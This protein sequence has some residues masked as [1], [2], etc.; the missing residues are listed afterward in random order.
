[1]HRTAALA[2]LASL[3]LAPSA[4]GDIVLLKDGRSI[5][6]IKVR[7]DGDFYVLQYVHG[8]VRLPASEVKDAYIEVNGAFEPR[9][10]EER[11]KV[12]Q[13]LV[14]YE[15]KWMKKDQRDAAMKKKQEAKKKQIAEL[16]AHSNWRDRYKASTANFTFEYTMTPDVAQ[17]YMDL[18][19]AYFKAFQK[20]WGIQKPPKLGKIPVCFY[21]DYPEFLRTSGAGYGV[22]AYYRFR[23]PLELDFFYDRYNPEVTKHIMFHEANHHLQHLIDLDFGYPH[24]FGEALAEYYGASTYDPVTKK[25]TIGLVQEGRLTEVLEDIR[26]K[27]FKKLEDYLSNKLGYED[28]T[29]GWTF[30]HFMMSTPKYAPRFRKFFLSLAK[31]DVKRSPHEYFS[32]MRTVEGTEILATFRKSMGI[33]DLPALEKEWYD[34]IQSTLKLTSERG[35]EEAGDAAWRNGQRLKA[36]RFY[37]QALDAGSKSPSV[38]ENYAE[39]LMRKP[40][41]VDEAIALLKKAVGH[42]PLNASLYIAL[43]RAHRRK[44]ADDPAA[45]D[46]AARMYGLA[47]DIDPDVVDEWAL[48]EEALAEAGDDGG[49]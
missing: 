49:K 18:M 24:C 44:G 20:D 34:Y 36:A 8:D 28:Y 17:G 9:T 4:L 39:H 11:E 30:V 41:G 22:L 12:A 33:A 19:E 7:K 45:K 26:K 16:K 14:P 3:L 31:G 21:S 10:D 46:E 35:F 13:G 6:D 1:M 47:Q 29:W 25:L 27:E 48:I 42:D 23:K 40:E 15:G 32:D 37:K 2:V 38:H 5:E 43:A